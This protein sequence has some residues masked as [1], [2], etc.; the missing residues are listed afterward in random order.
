MHTVGT[1][2]APNVSYTVGLPQV[3]SEDVFSDLVHATQMSAMAEERRKLAVE[4]QYG[5]QA[6]IWTKPY[7]QKKY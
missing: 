3:V 7:Q 1:V 6:S 2:K 5:E 4:L